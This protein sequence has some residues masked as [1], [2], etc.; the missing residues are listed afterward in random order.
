MKYAVAP[1]TRPVT[2]EIHALIDNNLLVL[3]VKDDGGHG[4]SP[5]GSGLGV[6]LDNV[7][8]RLDL[9]YG[10][11]ATLRSGPLPAGGFEVELRLPLELK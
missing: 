6:G 3:S 10:S 1:S 9:M 2:I 5:E 8:R 11:A 4:G 7:K